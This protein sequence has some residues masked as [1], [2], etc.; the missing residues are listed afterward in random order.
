MTSSKQDVPGPDPDLHGPWS[1]LD[2]L[3]YSL[4]LCLAQRPTRHLTGL[5]ISCLWG[6]SATA[7]GSPSEVDGLASSSLLLVETVESL[8]IGPEWY[9]HA[10]LG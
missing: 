10:G 8:K 2:P 1:S 9:T 3:R 6:L 4:T 7:V 5:W